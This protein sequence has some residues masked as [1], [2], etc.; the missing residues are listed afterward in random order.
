MMREAGV[1]AVSGKDFDTKEGHKYVRFSYAG[2]KEDIQ[3]AMRRLKNWMGKNE[4]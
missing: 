1:V 3:E 2:T 4:R